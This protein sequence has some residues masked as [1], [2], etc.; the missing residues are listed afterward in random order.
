[1]FIERIRR[2]RSYRRFYE[3]EPISEETLIKLV[4]YAR[5]SPSAANKQ[6]REYFRSG[7][8]PLNERICPTLA[9]AGYLAD[10]P[11]PEP[12]ERPSAYIVIL[13]DKENSSSAGLDPGIAAQSILLGATEMGL[14]GCMIGSIRREEL[15]QV[16]GLSERYEIV[17]VI[18]LGKPKERVVLDEVGPDG[19]IRY[20][21]EPD[22]THHVPKRRLEEIILS[23]KRE[24][25]S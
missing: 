17:L 7:E 3:D 8:E 9:W 12:G 19:D 18:A 22:G 1:M 2:N 15:A 16:L 24:L 25:P 13:L 21:R 14:G 20:W 5:L 11:G 4:N 6:P 10:W 23:P